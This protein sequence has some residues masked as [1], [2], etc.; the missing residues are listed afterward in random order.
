MRDRMRTAI[1]LH[2]EGLVRYLVF[3]GG[4]GR[5]TVHETEAMT[6]LALEALEALAEHASERQA[7]QRAESSESA[8]ASGAFT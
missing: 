7:L 2:Q 6:R 4:P 5:G 3:S 1:G 8:K